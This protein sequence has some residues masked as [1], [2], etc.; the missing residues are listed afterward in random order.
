VR[1]GCTKERRVIRASIQLY[2]YEKGVGCGCVGG[3]RGAEK[4]DTSGRKHS[5]VCGEKGSLAERSFRFPL[6][7][8]SVERG[9]T[10]EAL[11]QIR[12]E[13]ESIQNCFCRERWSGGIG[14]MI[15]RCQVGSGRENRMDADYLVK[16][17][18]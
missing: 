2:I 14:R 5:W 16:K 4:E 10:A 3:P 7:G 8:G 1:G 15:C 11:L 12:E 18:E 6:Q 13:E 9:G 17:R